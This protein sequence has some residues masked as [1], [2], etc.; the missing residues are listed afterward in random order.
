MMTAPRRQEGAVPGDGPRTWLRGGLVAAG[1]GAALTGLILA[2]AGVLSALAVGVTLA[3]LGFGLLMIPAIV[4]AGRGLASQIR[5][6][7]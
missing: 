2:E 4:L 7:S 5:R 6:G 1:R 3:G